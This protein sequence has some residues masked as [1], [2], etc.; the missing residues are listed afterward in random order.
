MTLEEAK[1]IIKLKYPKRKIGAVGDEGEHFI[2]EAADPSIADEIDPYFA[3]EKKTGKITYYVPEDIIEFA[4]MMGY[5][6]DGQ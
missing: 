2:V 5:G 4:D 1:K 6:E 3:V